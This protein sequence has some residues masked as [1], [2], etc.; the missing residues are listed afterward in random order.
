MATLQ[1]RHKVPDLNKVKRDLP[2]G[3]GAILDRLI[4][5]EVLEDKALRAVNRGITSEQ[6][7]ANLAAGLPP[8][9]I[10]YQEPKLLADDAK[11]VAAYKNVD[12]KSGRDPNAGWG[13]VGA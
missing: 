3:R 11:R 8:H 6:I 9:W 5:L 10:E 12:E 7:D 1:E 13:K 4:E 2:K